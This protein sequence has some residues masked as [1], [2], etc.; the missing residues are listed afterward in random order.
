MREPHAKLQQLL[1][2]VGLPWEE[3]LLAQKVVSKG[4]RRGE[5]GFDAGAADRWRDEI[6]PL[7]KCSLELLL[8]HRMRALGYEI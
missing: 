6:G 8:S 3:G 2:F 4:S 7:A 5:V 1:G